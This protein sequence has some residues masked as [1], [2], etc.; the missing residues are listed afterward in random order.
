MRKALLTEEFLCL[1]TSRERAESIA[2]D[3]VE[4]AGTRGIVWLGAAL[5]SVAFAL[6]FSAFGAARSR[7]LWLF[8]RGLLVWGLLYVV[9]RF[10]GAMIGIQ[11]LLMPSTDYAALSPGVQV[12]LASTLI[13][14]AFL[15]GLVLG[16]RRTSNG[17]NAATPLAMFW[18]L[19][20]VVAPLMDLAAGT[21]TWYCTFLYLLG[22]PLCYLFPLL[23]GG[24]LAG[25]RSAP[26]RGRAQR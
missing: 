13:L 4:E 1:I 6:F 23:A 2:G 5:A 15:T 18:A 11:P 7:T 9:V 14:A 16:G 8:G 25:R 12:Y 10:V 24:A 17:L 22:L 19:S 21:A 26:A 20:V 3:L